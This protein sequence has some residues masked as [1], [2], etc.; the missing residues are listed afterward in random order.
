MIVPHTSIFRS[1]TRKVILALLCQDDSTCPE[2]L[3]YMTRVQRSAFGGVINA[4]IHLY[5]NRFEDLNLVLRKVS[6]T[7]ALTHVGPASPAINVN[8]SSPSQTGRPLRRE[9]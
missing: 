7:R 5:P 9:M 4:P 2:L 3:Y 1:C 6:E 8:E